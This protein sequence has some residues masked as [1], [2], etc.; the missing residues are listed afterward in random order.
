MI[1]GFPTETKQEFIETIEFLKENDKNIDLISFSVFGLQKNTVIYN[2]PEKFGIKKIIED[3]RT[4]LEPV[5]SYELDES[6][7][8]LSQADARKLRGK[9]KKT[10]EKINKY[11][12][13]MNFFREHMFC[14]IK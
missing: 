6:S 9:Y 8:G 13:T 11:P 2:N 7:G 5:I 3:D 10:I 4:I 12:K 14:M 1:V